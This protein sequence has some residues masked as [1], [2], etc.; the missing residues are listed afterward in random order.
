MA[1]T[2]PRD[3]PEAGAAR[4]TF[5]PRR[6]DFLA[7]ET[8]GRVGAVS[9]GPPLWYAKWTLGQGGPRAADE[10]KAFVDSLDGPSRLFVGRDLSRPYPLAYQDTELQGLTR[11]S[12]G[13]F[14]GTATWSLSTATDGQQLLAMSGLPADFRFTT[15][16]Y[17]GFRWETAGQRRCTK[18]R[19]I[20]TYTG[21]GDGW[22]VLTPRPAVPAVVTGS[23]V[24]HLDRPGCLMRLIPG[25]TTI[26]DM[27]RRLASAV[28]VAAIQDL[29]P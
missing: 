17:I 14:D 24:L 5:E 20:E 18:V 2:F 26:G 9:V 22:A 21:T 13:A 27:D 7:P 6:M 15:G 3:M 8:G 12:G 16:D 28:T 23:A 11:A 4:Q 29:V 1:I 19:V 25:E 10:W